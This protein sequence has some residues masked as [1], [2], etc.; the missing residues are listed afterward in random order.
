MLTLHIT[1]DLGLYYFQ[2]WS[3]KHRSDNKFSVDKIVVLI[4]NWYEHSITHLLELHSVSDIHIRNTLKSHW[5]IFQCI[6]FQ[7]HSAM[8]TPAIYKEKNKRLS[9]KISA[10]LLWRHLLSKELRKR[11]LP[12][13]PQLPWNMTNLF[14]GL[15]L[16]AAPHPAHAWEH[17]CPAKQ[18][19]SGKCLMT[20]VENICERWVQCAPLCRARSDNLTRSQ[21]GLWIWNI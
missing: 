19:H 15:H 1:I 21:T 9:F 13:Q 11:C 3:R 5:L 18:M 4:P 6:S 8:S 7:E 14:R 17:L 12:N 16:R 20:L 2:L 10:F